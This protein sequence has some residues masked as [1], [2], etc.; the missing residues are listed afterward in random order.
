MRILGFLFLIIPLQPLHGQQKEKFSKIFQFSLTPGISTNGM[1]PGG[2]SNMVSL[3]LTSGYSSANYLLEIGV[4]S[5]LNESETRGIQI[6][7]VANTTGSNTFAAMQQKEIE[8]MKKS[9]FE[10]NLSGIQ[11]SSITNL[12]LNN[13]FGA[14][15][16]GGVNVAKGALQGFQLAGISN[17]TGKY[18]FGMQLSGIYNISI[19][20]MD[21]VQL[22]GVFNYTSGGLHGAQIS[23]FNRA[24]FIEGKNSFNNKDLTGIQIGLMNKADN[25]NGFQIGIINIGKRMQGTQIGII[26]IYGNGKTPQTADGTSLGLLNIGSSGYLSLYANDIFLQ[27][28]EIATGTVKN[29]RLN[30]DAREKQ[31]QNGLIYARSAMN[32]QPGWALGYGIKKYFFNRSLTPGMSHFNFFALGV[33]FLHISQERKRLTKELSLLSRPGISIGSRIHPKN[34]NVFLFASAAY[35]IYRFESGKTIESIF[36]NNDE[37]QTSGLQQWPGFSAGVLIQ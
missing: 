12:V 26:N 11:I 25:M 10:A 18:S 34:K 35:N 4:V 3:N 13:V 9:G 21:G 17:T 23:L 7:G 19:E 16:T 27:N 28:I 32:G 22:S 6:A 2:Y 1:H 29:R 24:G 15:I 8:K 30:A 36:E 33:D 37:S 20:S 5:N 31:I 14:Q